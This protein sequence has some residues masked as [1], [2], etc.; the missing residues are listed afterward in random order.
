[1]CSWAKFLFAH[2]VNAWTLSLTFVITSISLLSELFINTSIRRRKNFYFLVL[3][4][5]LITEV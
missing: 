2:P 1:M 4:L 5:V 3:M